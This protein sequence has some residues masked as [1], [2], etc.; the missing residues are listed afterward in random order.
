MARTACRGFS[1]IDLLG[2]AGAAD[3][4]ASIRPSAM[5]GRRQAHRPS[6]SRAF[7]GSFESR[8]APASGRRVLELS[9]RRRVDFGMCHVVGVARKRKIAARRLWRPK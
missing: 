4:A 6:E 3:L 2:E 7:V 1:S 8:A 5:L 9:T